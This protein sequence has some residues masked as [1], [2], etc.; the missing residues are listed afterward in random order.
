MYGKYS[1]EA[2]TAYDPFNVPD[3]TALAHGCLYVD[4]NGFVKAKI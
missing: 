3:H 2:S 1:I 4:Q